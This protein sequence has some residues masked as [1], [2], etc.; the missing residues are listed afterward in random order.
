M[1]KILGGVMVGVVIG[2]AVLEILNRNNPKLIKQVEEKA[3][4]TARDFVDAFR[5]GYG[6]IKGVKSSPHV[7]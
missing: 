5:E 1:W 4:S 3:E 7:A 6:G 2:A